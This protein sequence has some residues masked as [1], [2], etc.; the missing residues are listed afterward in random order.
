MED[1]LLPEIQIPEQTNRELF[2]TCLNTASSQYGE[3]I[4]FL[5]TEE[6]TQDKALVLE[7]FN[8]TQ[9]RS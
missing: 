3:L 4:Q 7:M 6:S 5:M 2:W 8:V 9:T 1:G